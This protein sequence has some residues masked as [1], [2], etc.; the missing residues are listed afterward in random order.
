[1]SKDTMTSRERWLA[2]LNREKPDRIPMDYWA[3]EEATRNLCAH[4]ECDFDEACTRLH[5]DR[6]LTVGGKYVGPPL[7]EETNVFGIKTRLV[8]YGA[9]RYAESVN[10][11]LA[12]YNSVVEIEAHYTW[13]SPDWWDYSHL[14]ETVKGNEDCIVQGGLS[15]PMLTYKRLRG[16]A[17]AFMDL[18]VNSDIVHYCLGKLFALA[19]Q[20]ALRIFETIPGVV[21]ITYVAEDLGGQGGCCTRPSTSAS[22]SCPA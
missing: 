19:Y 3:T 14:P 20:D 12:R 4:L 21:S 1:M 6:R 18:H 9:G 15:E 22:S 13:P 10:A 7:A 11:P 16:E 2:V 8:D 17:Q 5:I